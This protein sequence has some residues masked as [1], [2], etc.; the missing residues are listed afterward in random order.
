MERRSVQG[1]FVHLARNN[2]AFAD[3]PVASHILL[4]HLSLLQKWFTGFLLK[5]PLTKNRE[6]PGLLFALQ[7]DQAFLSIGTRRRAATNH[8]H[9][10]LKLAR[11][12][13]KL[14]VRLSLN[15]GMVTSPFTT[16]S[17]HSLYAFYEPSSHSKLCR[18]TAQGVLGHL[19]RNISD[20][21]EDAP[22]LYRRA[23]V[24][25]TALSF[26]HSGLGRL[27]RHRFVGENSNPHLPMTAKKSRHGHT[28]RLDLLGRNVPSLEGLDPKLT[29][30]N[31]VPALA[32]T[33]KWPFRDFRNFDFFG[34]KV[35]NSSSRCWC[36]RRA[37]PS[38]TTSAA[39][40]R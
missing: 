20:L 17:S 27:L 29:K 18:R 37:A 1:Q 4:N 26:S 11:S 9:L 13:D 38:E 36:C 22:R 7:R 2:N 35:M 5:L 10:A 16:T 8:K 25:D 23:I 19:P 40:F 12:S 31:I 24:V 39:L 28:A 3:L 21:E 32:Q 14:S 6:N 30:I 33:R 15:S 34:I